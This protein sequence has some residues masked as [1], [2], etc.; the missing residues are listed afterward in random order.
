MRPTNYPKEEHKKHVSWP[1]PS[2]LSDTKHC[3]GFHPTWQINPQPQ[4]IYQER[5]RKCTNLISQEHPALCKQ[6]LSNN[7]FRLTW[8]N[9]S[10]DT[11]WNI[12]SQTTQILKFQ[13]GRYLGDYWQTH[14][15]TRHTL[16]CNLCTSHQHDTWLCLLSCR[17]N[18]HIN[19]LWTNQHNKATHT[20][21]I[22]TTR[23]FPLKDVGKIRDNTPKNTISSWYLMCTCY[24]PWCNAY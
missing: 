11:P 9:F 22:P 15:E 4:K 2:T 20:L 8:P 18:K 6:W 23:C 19:N 3:S 21:A 10:W 24:F 14:P 13:Y 17:R 1:P 7:G 16:L 12:D 5:M